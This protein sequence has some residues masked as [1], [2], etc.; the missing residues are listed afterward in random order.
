[1][2]A[3]VVRGNIEG[4]KRVLEDRSDAYD[5]VI[6]S[7]TARKTD[8]TARWHKNNNLKLIRVG[9]R[10]GDRKHRKK[11]T[12]HGRKLSRYGERIQHTVKCGK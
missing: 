4:L 12:H 5:H 7:M 1:M 10:S 3:Q 6:K 8:P 11:Y 9:E 2:T